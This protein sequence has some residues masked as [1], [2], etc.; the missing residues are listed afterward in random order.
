MERGVGKVSNLESQKIGTKW[1]LDFT[2]CEMTV[3]F[4]HSTGQRPIPSSPEPAYSLRTFGFLGMDKTV[5][6]PTSYLFRQY[7]EFKLYLR[8]NM[9]RGSMQI[10]SDDSTPN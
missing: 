7:F 6:G 1:G 9:N 10:D 8:R 4:K 5:P 3:A 2:N